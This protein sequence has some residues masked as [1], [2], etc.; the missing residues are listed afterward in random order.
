MSLGTDHPGHQ[1]REDQDS[2]KALPKDDHRG[3]RYDR[4]GRFRAGAHRLLRI[5][6]RDIQCSARCRHLLARR[7]PLEKLREPL[8]LVRSV[9][10][11]ALAPDEEILRQPPEALLRAELEEGVRLEPRRLSLPVLTR[12]DR[13]L[14][15]VERRL[16]HVEIG[17]RPGVL[18]LLWKD[19]VAQIECPLRICLDRR[20]VRDLI[21]TARG[22]QGCPK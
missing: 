18:P 9:P 4:G 10:E 15:A 16:D 21:A 12:G 19:V 11:E 2:F 22:S 6:Q 7:V 14:H 1:R 13:T 5:A 3:V 20:R 8:I 17:R